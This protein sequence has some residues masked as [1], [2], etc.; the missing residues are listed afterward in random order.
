MGADQLDGCDRRVEGVRLGNHFI[1]PADAQGAQRHD[2]GI[3]AGIDASH[4]FR[5]QESR[6]L[7]FELL[8][9]GRQL[10]PAGD[11]HRTQVRDQRVDV[12]PEL[13]R[14]VVASDLHGVPSRGNPA[15]PAPIRPETSSP[16][17]WPIAGLKWLRNDRE[18]IPP[19]LWAMIATF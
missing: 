17:R 15:I 9:L 3:R 7:L 12:G 6:Q 18:I 13:V 10:V 14:V 8:H 16:C 19:W 11:E 1:A 4:V 5:A 2:Q